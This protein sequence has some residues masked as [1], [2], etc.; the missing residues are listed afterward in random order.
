MHTSSGSPLPLSPD[1]TGVSYVQQPPADYEMG[2]RVHSHSP[3]SQVYVVRHNPASPSNVIH[4]NDKKTK[5]LLPFPPVTREAQLHHPK[6]MRLVGT[7]SGVA[8]SE[9]GDENGHVRHHSMTTSGTEGYET[10][11]ETQS[12]SD[13]IAANGSAQRLE[14]TE[15]E[16]LTIQE[17]LSVEQ[18]IKPISGVEAWEM[19]LGETVKRIGGDK[20][21][22]KRRG[23]VAEISRKAGRNP[24]AGRN[25]T[26]GTK[27]DRADSLKRGGIIG[28]FDPQDEV[29][30]PFQE[31]GGDLVDIQQNG[32]DTVEQGF[33]TR[34]KCLEEK[35]RTIA[36]RELEVGRREETV[37]VQERNLLEQKASEEERLENIRRN[38]EVKQSLSMREKRLEEKEWTIAS[39]E[40]EVEH[41][42]EVVCGQERG[43][44]ERE[45]S[46]EE[47]LSTTHKQLQDAALELEDRER[48]LQ[49][50]EKAVELKEMEV[51]RREKD[52]QLQELKVKEWEKKVEAK[53]TALEE[54]IAKDTLAASVSPWTI[55]PVD[56]LRRCWSLIGP[57]SSPSTTISS[58]ESPHHRTSSWAIRR[59][60]LFGPYHSGGY[61]VLMSIGVCVVALRVLGKKAGGFVGRG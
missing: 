20:I 35:E 52:V 33:A 8:E 10:A 26:S 1:R 55:M 47:R 15:E 11:Q 22:E 58:P 27:R 37:A 48:A 3:H 39:R 13:S 57:S 46:E 50:K 51:A 12:D 4:S 24:T 61:F 45:A 16:E 53:E 38:G 19:E 49:F 40:L 31:E 60:I 14:H 7:N 21:D 36:T 28:L 23:S 2:F 18:G 44:C 30:A 17:L 34:E 41:R 59:D 25:G 54:R 5:R 9:S 43:L 32:E 56:L 6:P 42:E 29:Q